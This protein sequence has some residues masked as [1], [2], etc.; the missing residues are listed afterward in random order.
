MRLLLGWFCSALILT[1][2]VFPRTGPHQVWDERTLYSVSEAESGKIIIE[3]EKKV[4]SIPLPPGFLFQTVFQ[5]APYATLRDK[6]NSVTKLFKYKHHKGQ[7][8]LVGKLP[9]AF[10]QPA[11][12]LPLENNTFFILSPLAPMILK[13]NASQCAIG[14]V[15]EKGEMS[16][17]QLI[18]LKSNVHLWNRVSL[19]SIDGT[20][21][22][23][24]DLNSNF[25]YLLPLGSVPI[26][27]TNHYYLVSLNSVGHFFI[28]SKKDGSLH[29]I[30]ILHSSIDD[31][32]LAKNSNTEQIVLGIQPL[33]D[34]R[35]VIA[36]RTEDAALSA[37]K[38]FQDRPSNNSPEQTAEDRL[39][40]TERNNRDLRND[41]VIAFP[42]IQW[43][44]LEPENGEFRPYY[45]NLSP[46]PRQFQG[47][48][49]AEAFCFKIDLKNQILIL[50]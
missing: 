8:E 42:E 32:Y 7:W 14:E 35:C 15:D 16:L 31:A 4:S 46:L 19:L 44:V 25:L 21:H 30:S 23:R 27:S 45:G 20:P 22:Y 3:G 36:S 28:F 37:R 10:G 9:F 24:F 11:W 2:Q 1:A 34:G 40:E 33:N 12:M 17:S 18:R 38:I 43:H 6:T 39:R 13:D 26:I 5:G 47:L 41:S 50:K 49:S 48:K 29:Q